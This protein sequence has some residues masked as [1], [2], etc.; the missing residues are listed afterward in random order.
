M[1]STNVQRREDESSEATSEMPFLQK[2]RHEREDSAGSQPSYA[3]RATTIAFPHTI[4]PSYTR[5]ASFELRQ[6]FEG[7]VLS[8]S[9]DEFEARLMDRTRPSNPNEIASF[10][11]LDVSEGD[12]E[13]LQPGAVFY[14]S[15]G[16]RIQPWGQRERSSIIRFRRVPVWTRS[17]LGQIK[18]QAESWAYMLETE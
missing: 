14:W 11:L 3:T 1:V 9:Q 7:T 10:S 5:E 15:I 12:R 4:E 17:E 8:I 6:Q 18:K 2:S 16:Y 13:L